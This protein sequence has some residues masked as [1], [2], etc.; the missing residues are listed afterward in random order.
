MKPH[1][2]IF[3][4]LSRAG[5]SGARYWQRKVAPLGVTAA[6]SLVLLFLR[7]QDGVTSKELGDKIEFDSATLTGL[8]D[9]LSNAGL[10][11][12]RSHP[13]DRRAI[14]VHLTQKG[15]ATTQRISRMVDAENRSFLSNLTPEEGLILRSLLKK[16][17]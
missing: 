4:Q 17:G 13:Q 3:F 1:D 6:Q 14:L 8:L 12:R 16:L 5:R 10:V 2:C 11:E 7:E 15:S 9:R